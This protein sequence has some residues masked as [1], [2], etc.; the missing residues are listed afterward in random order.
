MRYVP[1]SRF[2]RLA[3]LFLLAVVLVVTTFLLP[4]RKPGSQKITLAM[5]VDNPKVIADRGHVTKA[6]FE[7]IKKGMT[8]DEVRGILDR[9]DSFGGFGNLRGIWTCWY[10]SPDDGALISVRFNWPRDKQG[11]IPPGQPKIVS[12]A[13]FREGRENVEHAK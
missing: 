11:D 13:Q 3:G 9:A 8:F 7:R 6:N 2:S 10:N 1:A 4:A 12:D 5:K